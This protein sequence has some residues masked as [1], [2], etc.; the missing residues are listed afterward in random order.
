VWKLDPVVTH[1]ASNTGT[2]SRIHLILDC[3]MNSTLGRLLD[4]AIL[5][6][7]N[8][9]RLPPLGTEERQ[10]IL[11][12]AQELLKHAGRE[13]AEQ[14][15]LNLFHRF[16]LR[17]ESSYN[18]LIDFYGA[19]GFEGREKYWIREEV[20]RIYS[21]EKL[22]PDTTTTKTTTKTQN[23]LLSVLHPSTVDLPQVR[24]LQ[25]ILA[26]M[27]HHAGLEKAYVRGSLARRHRRPPLRH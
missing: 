22:D 17:Q 3:Y 21:R 19:M 4:G 23:T 5:E 7:Q 9:Q 18:I 11:R 27:E 24:I 20:A 14:L 15:L 8:C 12:E 26:S 16:E 6:A 10:K 1:A 13:K 2:D 25:K